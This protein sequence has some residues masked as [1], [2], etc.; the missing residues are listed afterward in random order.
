MSDYCNFWNTE[1]WKSFNLYF[2]I[3]HLFQLQ[4]H[5]PK[6]RW[7]FAKNSWRLFVKK[8]KLSSSSDYPIMFKF[9]SLWHKH[10]LRNYKW[11][12]RL[13]MSAF[14]TAI[15][16]TL[17]KH[18]L[19]TRN[20][21]FK[22]FHVPLLLITVEVKNAICNSLITMFTTSWRNLIKIGWSE[23]YKMLSFFTKSR[24]KC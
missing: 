2:S 20:F 23:L 4:K 22:L 16:N 17:S 3:K 8:L 6:W 13:P 14:A 21:A 10:L 24:F 9:A 7:R 12:V 18:Q 19:F 15:S 11:H 1:R 5:I